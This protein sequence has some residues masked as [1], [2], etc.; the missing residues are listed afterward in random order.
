MKR[1]LMVPGSL[2]SALH[3]TYF[4]DP[5]APR[6]ISHFIPVGK[7]A[8][9][10][11]RRSLALSVLNSSLTSRRGTN[12]RTAS[13]RRPPAYGSTRRGTGA[14]AGSWCV[15]GAPP[16]IDV[17]RS[18]SFSGGPACQDHGV[19]DGGGSPDAAPEAGDVPDLCAGQRWPP[20]L[21]PA[22]TRTRSS[23]IGR[24]VAARR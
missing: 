13:Y 18:F 4:G 9:P 1:S 24:Q 11:P 16:A 6:T 12:A 8:P 5:A 3:T 20:L 17:M 2:S 21:R 14:G 7:P 10:R 22:H 23:K 15:T 19:E